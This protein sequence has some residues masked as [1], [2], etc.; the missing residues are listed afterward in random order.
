MHTHTHAR[1][2]QIHKMHALVHTYT[3]I[4][5]YMH[6]YIHTYTYIHM[7]LIYPLPVNCE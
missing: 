3:F 2:T 6:A 4:H 7:H 5:L 1:I